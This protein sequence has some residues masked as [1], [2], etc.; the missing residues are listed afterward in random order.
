MATELQTNFV[1]S[2]NFMMIVQF[3]ITLIVPSAEKIINLYIYG[4]GK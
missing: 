2:Q 3:V 1:T 4:P